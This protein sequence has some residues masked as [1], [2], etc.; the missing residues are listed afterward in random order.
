MAV[1]IRILEQSTRNTDIWQPSETTRKLW[2]WVGTCVWQ[3]SLFSGTYVI[4][5]V[6]D[7]AV[8][9]HFHSYKVVRSVNRTFSSVGSLVLLYNCSCYKRITSPRVQSFGC[10]MWLSPWT[11]VI[12][13]SL[14]LSLSGSSSAILHASRSSLRVD[15]LTF[16]RSAQKLFWQQASRPLFYDNWRHCGDVEG[17]EINRDCLFLSVIFRVRCMRYF[18][19]VAVCSVDI[20]GV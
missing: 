7:A 16:Q 8:S 14:S 1:S 18:Y 3:I 2:D 13:I 9:I 20:F 12:S 17:A 19:K 6:F 4:M 11:K 5:C 15:L 10:H